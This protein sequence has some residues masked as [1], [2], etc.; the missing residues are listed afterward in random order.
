MKK[1]LIYLMVI[2]SCILLCGC[3]DTSKL[4]TYYK[5]MNAFNSNVKIITE[6][7]DMIDVNSDTAPGQVVAQLEKM[8]EQFRIL[9]EIEVPKHFSANEEMAD[10]AYTYMQEAVRLYKEWY[11]SADRSNTSVVQM[12]KE[13]YDRAMTRVNYISIVLQGD[14]PSGE[15]I[16][17]TEEETTDFTPVIDDNSNY[18]EEFN[19]EYDDESTNQ[20]IN[21]DSTDGSLVEE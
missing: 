3:G 15:G 8:E 9:S 14:V 6:T 2:A 4:D 21:I 13:N 18:T 17:V 10:D 5:E 19:V 20:D 12:A 1:F 16:V 7:M 11:S